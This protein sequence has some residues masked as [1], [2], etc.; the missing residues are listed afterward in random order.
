MIPPKRFFEYKGEIAIMYAGTGDYCHYIILTKA[1]AD[2][3]FN[4][5]KD[6]YDANT[7]YNL[8]IS[9]KKFLQFNPEKFNENIATF[10]LSFKITDKEYVNGYIP[11]FI[12]PRRSYKR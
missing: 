7:L 5:F 8:I 12:I 10:H 3:I 1:L 4:F 11:C 9:K 6:K 2:D